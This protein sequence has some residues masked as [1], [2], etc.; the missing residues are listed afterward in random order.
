MM[1]DNHKVIVLP[2]SVFDEEM[3][4]MKLDDSNVEDVK[5]KAFIS[6][7]GTPECLAY[8]LNEP[9]TK[10]WFNDNHSN[11]LNLDFDDLGEDRVYEGHLFKA[12]SDEQAEDVV[13]FIEDN[14][15][16]DFIIHCRAGKSRSQAIGLFILSNYNKHFANYQPAVEPYFANKGVLRKLNRI[17][18]KRAIEKDK[19]TD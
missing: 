19:L 8:Y 3:E 6:I 4:R 17:L 14:L 2:Q 16:K 15:G 10:H 11:V 5:D 18:W 1:E 12:M 7:I 9:D 13:R